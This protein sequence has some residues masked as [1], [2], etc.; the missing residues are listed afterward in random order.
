MPLYRCVTRTQ[1]TPLPASTA[2]A[3]LRS[4]EGWPDCHHTFLSNRGTFLFFNVGKASSPQE[5]SPACKNQIYFE[6]N[7]R[8]QIFFLHNFLNCVISAY[9]QLIHFSNYIL[10]LTIDQQLINQALQ[11]SSKVSDLLTCCIR[12]ELHLTSLNKTKARSISSYL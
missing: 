4:P 1:S 12:N 5:K 6:S 10:S 11:W 3:I 2:T 9:L 7:L 8:E